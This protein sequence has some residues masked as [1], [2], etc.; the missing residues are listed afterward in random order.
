[1]ECACFQVEAVLM[2]WADNFFIAID[3]ALNKRCAAVRAK[4]IKSEKNF[5]YSDYPDFFFAKLYPSDGF[6]WE[7][8]DDIFSGLT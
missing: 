7:K 8:I 6:F 3:A 2:K 1:M 4:T 5:S